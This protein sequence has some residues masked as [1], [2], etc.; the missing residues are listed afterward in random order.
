MGT[1][2]CFL[3]W[4]SVLQHHKSTKVRPTWEYSIINDYI[5][6]KKPQQSWSRSTIT[7]SFIPGYKR[8]HAAEPHG[9]TLKQVVVKAFKDASRRVPLT[10]AR[11]LHP[12]VLC[13]LFRVIS[14]TTR[15]VGEDSRVFS[16]L[17]FAMYTG[18][19]VVGS[20]LSKHQFRKHLTGRTK[21]IKIG[22]FPSGLSAWAKTLLGEKSELNISGQLSRDVA[23]PS[24]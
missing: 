24:V 15:R 6:N 23:T 17:A 13:D 21:R 3:T 1:P 10:P 22:G 5:A 8:L 9:A 11:D 7:T 12:F 18:S 19:S 4:N 2:G 14:L 20:T 16:L